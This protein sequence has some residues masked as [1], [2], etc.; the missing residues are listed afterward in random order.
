MRHSKFFRCFCLYFVEAK[1]PVTYL[2]WD[3]PADEKDGMGYE[4]SLNEHIN[5]VNEEE[6]MDI[7][8]IMKQTYEKINMQLPKMELVEVDINENPWD[9]VVHSR[10]ILS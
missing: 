3:D 4:S 5:F 7:F 6:A 2:D 10:K 9:K 8:E 1:R